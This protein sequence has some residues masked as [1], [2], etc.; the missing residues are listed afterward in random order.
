MEEKLKKLY[1]QCIQELKTIGI[2]FEDNDDIGK[3]DI[4]LSRRTTKRYGCCK[5]KNPDKN[6][7]VIEKRGTKRITTYAKFEEHH[8]EVSEWV[9]QLEDKIIK[10]TILHEMIHCIPFCNNHGKKFREYATYIN[11]NLGY[12]IKR[13]GNPKEDYERSNI[14]Y[15]EKEIE[16]R[17]K[18]KCKECGQKIYR[19]RLNARKINKYRCGKCGGELQLLS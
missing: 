13:V 10:N 16:Y 17:Y 6:F 4:S 7:K 8:I 1:N 2:D 3:I 5:Q 14:P 15:I 12:D 19:Q 9:M 11:Q 18:I